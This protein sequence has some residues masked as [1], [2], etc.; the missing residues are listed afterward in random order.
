MN[1]NHSSDFIPVEALL[2]K[3]HQRRYWRSLDEL[4][5]T[6][7]FRDMLETEFPEHAT[8]PPEGSSRRR[9]LSLMAGSAALAGLTACT[10]QPTEMI[11]PYVEPPE[12]AIPGVPKFYA[13]AVPVD[14]IAQGVIVES[15][16]GRPTKV[17][18]NP[19]HPA[20]LGASDVH[21]QACLMD[22]YD[23]DRATEILRLGGPESWQSFRF[24][25]AEA[26]GPIFDKQGDGLSILSE[27]VISP[28]LGAQIQA[29]LKAF[30]RAQ[31]RQWDPAGPHSARTAAKTAF[32]RPL[33][34]YY[35]FDQADVVVSLDSDFLACGAGTTRYARDFAV[36]RRRGDRMDMNRL[37]SVESSMTSTGGKADHR[38]PSR[39]A[40]IEAF[41]RNL[42]GIVQG[43]AP[44]SNI[45]QQRFLNAVAQDLMA[46]RG[47]SVV[48]PG[49]HQSPA[50]HAL[51]HVLNATLGNEGH[52]IFYTEP[53]EVQPV[54]QLQSLRSLVDDMRAGRVQM[55]LILGGNP[56]YNAPADFGFEDL[57]A[58]VPFSIHNS[59]HFDE[60]SLHT[61][62][63]IPDSHFLEDWGDTR[64][65]DGTITI[66]QP[67]IAP[68]YDSHS[69]LELLD[70]LVR[71]DGRTSYQIVRAYWSEHSKAGKDF[72]AW[73]RKSVHDGL[74]A[75]SALPP[76]QPA[77]NSAAVSGIASVH[78]PQ[79]IEVVF[80]PDV[81]IHDGRY[82]NN[83]WLQ[84]LP[85]PMSKLTWDNAI[86]M[87]PVTAERLHFKN[88]Q[89]VRLTLRDKAV[90]GSIWI[91]PG[92]P[93]ESITVHLGYG[94]WRSGTCRQR[95]GIQRLCDPSFRCV[96]VRRWRGPAS[97]GERISVGDH[98]D[99][100]VHGG[101]NPGN[102][103]TARAN[104]NPN[105]TSRKRRRKSLPII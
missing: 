83:M 8:E 6:P 70:L 103:R 62:W 84:E 14:G 33:N 2:T 68:L 52:T 16:L 73:W 21:S 34:T 55:L 25:L 36:R 89:N 85:H 74:I 61:T 81:Y 88:Q 93:E 39:Y 102:F 22:L 82:A 91:S 15:H 50:V 19:D 29:V 67:L 98:P 104:I 48:I 71:P 31:W 60:T 42:A 78:P 24:A 44:T 51:A 23:P 49:E 20:S 32:G 75:G 7:E 41:A 95:S 18:G 105:L 11:M 45:D 13:T 43:G 59:L 63:H 10:R 65:F 28:S 53:L 57:V 56:V 9:F 26:L 54:D 4:A 58:K 64:A 90:E 35:K 46:H 12:H 5:N 99:A 101:S 87:S 38:S 94:R 69:H 1:E 3:S 77:L 97:N 79:G 76:I 100:A 27:T 66:Q 86:H 40:D 92:H 17:E 30:P 72:E 47:A 80:C 96:V 37:Y